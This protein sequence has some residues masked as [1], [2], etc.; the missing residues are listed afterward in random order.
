MTKRIIDKKLFVHENGEIYSGLNTLPKN[1]KYTIGIVIDTAIAIPPTTGVTYRLYYL[2]KELARRG[3]KIIWILGNRNFESKSSL[4]ELSKSDIKTH[5]LPT[6]KFY[7]AKYVSNIL[8]AEKVDVVQYEITQ[9]FVDLGLKIRSLTKLPTILELHD[10][11]ATLR[12]TLN[13]KEESPFMK[14]LQYIAGEYADAIVCMTPVDYKTLSKTI[15]IQKER[16]FLA[17]NGIGL[18]KKLENIKKERDVL[19]FLGNLFYQPNQKAFIYIAEKIIPELNK[20]RRVVLKSIGMIPNNLRTRYEDNK[21]IVILGEIKDKKDFSLQVASSTIGLCT[22]FAGSGM[23]VK[24]LDY[25]LAELPIISTTIG[26]SGYEKM[27]NLIV[28]NKKNEIV[29]EINILL[30]DSKKAKKI[31]KNNKKDILKFYSWNSTIKNFERALSLAVNFNI[32]RLKKEQF[33]P[34]WLE[35][36][37]HKTRVLDDHYTIGKNFITKHGN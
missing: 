18:Q 9:T 13:R 15:K 23:K 10:V 33:C 16:L 3:Y 12:E 37:R 26:A 19:L 17:P 32:T 2:S 20:T 31:G 6:K 14:F 22:V 27:K 30:N 24:I 11:E 7:N 4:F 21:N 36:K 29:K 5:L 28:V 1:K 34:F 35:E 25:S 8:I